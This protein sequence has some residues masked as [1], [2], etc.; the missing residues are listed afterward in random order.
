MFNSLPGFGGAVLTRVRTVIPAQAHGQR[1][2]RALFVDAG[3]GCVTVV[4]RGGLFQWQ[5]IHGMITFGR[6]LNLEFDGLAGLEALETV[7]LD[8]G[9]VNEE[10]LAPFIGANESVPLGVVEPFHL[11]G[12]H[13]DTPAFPMAVVILVVPERV[14][15]GW[16]HRRHLHGFTRITFH[17]GTEAV[18]P[19]STGVM[20]GRR[21]DDLNRDDGLLH[22][23]QRY[24]NLVGEMHRKRSL[25]RVAK[26][27]IGNQ[28]PPDP[29]EPE[30]PDHDDDLAVEES[31]PGVE[32]PPMY[33]VVMLNDDYTPMEFV[34]EVLERFFGMNREKATQVMLTVHTEGRAICGVFTRDVAETKAD[35][36]VDYARENQHPLL[37]QVEQA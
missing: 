11:A 4:A 10:V 37:C 18:N 21:G 27:V 9:I 35:Q 24:K 14:D 12:S 5:Q 29:Q 17:R 2:F 34:V 26:L 7:H 13:G 23:Q 3:A 25:M 19:R 33:K 31:R 28:D 16:G 8:V 30:R 6:F 15:A 32:E 20:P 36:V 1:L 22:R